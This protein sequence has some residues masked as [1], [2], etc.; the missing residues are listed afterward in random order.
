[1]FVTLEKLELLVQEKRANNQAQRK[2]RNEL[3]RKVELFRML[4]EQN[5]QELA[6]IQM[7]KGL[8]ND[9]KGMESKLFGQD[10]GIIPEFPDNLGEE[11][12]AAF[13]DNIPD[14][15]PGWTEVGT[16]HD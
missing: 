12:D 4:N 15:I 16:D 7:N 11:L 9:A 2:F 14:Y 5:Q 3:R 6:L 13:A 8:F 10:S 1:M